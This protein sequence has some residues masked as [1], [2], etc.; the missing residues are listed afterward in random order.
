[1][2]YRK[3][4]SRVLGVL[5]VVVSLSIL[6]GCVP[7]KKESPFVRQVMVAKY[8]AT[9]VAIDGRLDDE[10]WKHAAVYPLCIKKPDQDAGKALQEGGEARLAWDNGNFYLAVTFTDSDIVA[11]GD[12][13]QL[14]HY[15]MGDLVEL[16][17]KPEENTWYWELYCTPKGNKTSFF[18]PGRGRLWLDSVTNYNCGL[19]VAAKNNGTLNNWEDK[20]TSWTAEMAMPIKDLCARG[21]VIAPGAKW[22]ILV[23][24]Y[25]YSRYL[26]W[27]EY[28]TAPQLPDLPGGYHAHE[29]YGQLVFEK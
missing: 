2:H 17:L 12:K 8:T 23:A 19:V 11:E 10:A 24:R 26:P 28:S 21:D 6:F 27:K 16:F 4:V 13:D 15:L 25:N 1:M 22:L 3:Y 9:P 29:G 5:V 18:F 7:S 20:D 14:H